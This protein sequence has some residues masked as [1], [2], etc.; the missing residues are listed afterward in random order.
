MTR[1]NSN[2]LC[3]SSR[4]PFQLGYEL[5]LLLYYIITEQ[6]FLV[7]NHLES[8]N[9]IL[10]WRMQLA[11]HSD[12]CDCWWKQINL[13]TLTATW[14]TKSL[15]RQESRNNADKLMDSKSSK[16]LSPYMYMWTSV[17]FAGRH[18][19][20]SP[21]LAW[22]TVK[23]KKNIICWCI[24]AICH[25]HNCHI[26]KPVYYIWTVVQRSWSSLNTGA[27]LPCVC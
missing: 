23:N 18:V 10:A 20:W 11:A 12:I 1:P 22:A 14:L 24:S 25:I 2:L 27:H 19:E 13:C 5:K 21:N 3:S 7:L 26:L 6:E 15:L 8:W 17:I 4:P 9:W 16:L